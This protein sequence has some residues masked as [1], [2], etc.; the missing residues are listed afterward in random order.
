MNITKEKFYTHLMKKG[1]TQNQRYKIIPQEL[2]R[3]I[4]NSQTCESEGAHKGFKCYALVHYDYV[5]SI[6]DIDEKYL[7]NVSSFFNL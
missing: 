5:L 3:E 1:P 4:F 2:V 6:S 7:F